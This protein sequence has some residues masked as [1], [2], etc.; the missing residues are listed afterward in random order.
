MAAL[1][2]SLTAI[3]LLIFI[4]SWISPPYP[5]RQ[6]CVLFQLCIP[7]Q[8]PLRAL[9]SFPRTFSVIQRA[10]QAPRSEH[11]ADSAQGKEESKPWGLLLALAGGCFPS[12]HFLAVI[13]TGTSWRQPGTACLLP[14]AHTPLRMLTWTDWAQSASEFSRKGDSSHAPRPATLLTQQR[15]SLRQLLNHESA[16]ILTS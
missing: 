3:L 10:K 5:R 1:C 4:W 2:F 16:I 6:E 14:W 11:W 8:G 12:S 13:Q 7:N 15:D 9:F